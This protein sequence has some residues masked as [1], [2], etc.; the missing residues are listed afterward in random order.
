MPYRRSAP[1]DDPPLWS[2]AAI[3]PP[4]L[5]IWAVIWSLAMIITPVSRPGAETRGRQIGFVFLAKRGAR[6]EDQRRKNQ[7]KVPYPAHRRLCSI[8][9]TRLGH[10][11]SHTMTPLDP[12]VLPSG[13]RARFVRDI[14]GLE[15]HVLEAGFDRPGRPLVVLLH[16]FPEIAYSWRKVMPALADAGFHA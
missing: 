11:A 15:V 14:N 16:G 7:R 8:G 4:F 13:I 3:K 10:S 6:R 2:R 12:A 5:D 1:G 9:H